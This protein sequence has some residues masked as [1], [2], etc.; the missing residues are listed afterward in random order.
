VTQKVSFIGNARRVTLA[1]AA[2]AA[3]LM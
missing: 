1:R 3:K 2:R